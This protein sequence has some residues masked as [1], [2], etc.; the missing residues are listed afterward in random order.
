MNYMNSNKYIKNIKKPILFTKDYY[1]SL[2]KMSD[3]EIKLFLEK[4]R[5]KVTKNSKGEY[6]LIHGVHRVC[7]MI[8]RLINNKPYININ[9]KTK[10][11]NYLS[12]IKK[13]R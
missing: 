6:C 7:C 2:D 8:N 3:D 11:S 4:N 5:I 9:I 1:L 12:F 13:I 10:D